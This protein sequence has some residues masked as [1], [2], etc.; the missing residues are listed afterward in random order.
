VKGRL[1]LEVIDSHGVGGVGF[2]IRRYAESVVRTQMRDASISS[3]FTSSKPFSEETSGLIVLSESS[4]KQDI[5]SRDVCDSSRMVNNSEHPCSSELSHD[6]PFA[7][8]GQVC[9]GIRGALCDD[10]TRRGSTAISLS[11]S[12]ISRLRKLVRPSA[13]GDVIDLLSPDKLPP[14]SARTFQFT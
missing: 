5:G 10:K 9:E 3:P 4:R 8:N 7:R 6:R 12:E 13:N 2:N 14:P 11:A 1:R